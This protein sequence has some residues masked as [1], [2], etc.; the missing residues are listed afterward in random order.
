MT[1]VETFYSNRSKEHVAFAVTRGRP[2][3]T[4]VPL[5][6]LKTRRQIATGKSRS[7]A[8]KALAKAL[9][10]PASEVEAYRRTAD[11]LVPVAA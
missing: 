5:E 2:M 3:P 11:G 1:R 8:V 7:E 4:N 9:G 10:I 6:E